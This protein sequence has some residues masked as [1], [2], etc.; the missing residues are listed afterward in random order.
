M[1]MQYKKIKPQVLLRLK[2]MQTALQYGSL[3][4]DRRIQVVM[5]AEVVT[6]LDALSLDSDRS[7]IL[8]QLALDFI[9]KHQ[10][11]ANRPE[12]ISIVDSEQ[13]GLNQMAQYLEER[14]Q[15]K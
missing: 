12:L 1:C 11:F 13:T 4:S 9:L 7:K 15:Q 14:E 8:T 6:A 3:K 10:H 5:P 2:D